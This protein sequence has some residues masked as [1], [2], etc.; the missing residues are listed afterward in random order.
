[1]KL[2]SIFISGL[3]ALNIAPAYASDDQLA[4]SEQ[5][6]NEFCS[7]CHGPKMVNP[8]TSSYDLRKY[9]RDKKQDFLSTV[10]AGK[11]DMPAWGDILSHEEVEVIWYYVSTRA[12]KLKFVPDEKVEAKKDQKV[13]EKKNIQ[14]SEA[15]KKIEPPRKNL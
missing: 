3:L 9:P 12:G 2:V 11:G 1:M 6:Y 7:H 13:E 5:L 15:K 14:S 8:G 10:K 4:A